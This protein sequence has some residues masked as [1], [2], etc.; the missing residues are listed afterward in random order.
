[1]HELSA[2]QQKYLHIQKKTQTSR[3]CIQNPDSVRFFIRMGIHC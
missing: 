2:A 1:M 3:L